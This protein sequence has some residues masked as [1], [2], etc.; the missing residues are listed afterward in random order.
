MP[1]PAL[2]DHDLLA[3]R[4][5]RAAS[6]GGADFLQEAVAD[7][8]CRIVEAWGATGE[9]PNC[10]NL[11][12]VNPATHTLVIRHADEVGVLARV[13]NMLSEAQINVQQME[14]IIFSGD[15]GAAC[16]RLQ[17]EGSPEADLL[18][19]LRDH[20]HVFDVSLKGI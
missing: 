7:E 19:R 10:V 9:A 17:I 11:A 12:Q 3:L 14:N 2:F 15:N 1:I 5:A 20:P 8:A 18:A 13:L 16:A 4:R 6:L